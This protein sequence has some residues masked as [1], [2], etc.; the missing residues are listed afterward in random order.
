MW[1]VVRVSGDEPQAEHKNG[2]PQTPR[3]LRIIDEDYRT[4]LGGYYIRLPDS[5]FR[6]Y[7]DLLPEC[8]SRGVV[9]VGNRVF[10]VASDDVSAQFRY[11]IILDEIVAAEVGGTLRAEG[12]LELKRPFQEMYEGV[13]FPIPAVLERFLV[14]VGDEEIRLDLHCEWIDMRTSKLW[15]AAESDGQTEGS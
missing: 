4:D 5:A 2:E 7:G 3:L 14:P 15:E 6:A 13:Y 10:F 9:W 1:Q 8:D 11:D 12:V